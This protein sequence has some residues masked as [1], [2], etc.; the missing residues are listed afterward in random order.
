[1]VGITPTPDCHY[2]FLP[3][4]L[5]KYRHIQYDGHHAGG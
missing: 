3:H 2:L 1:M 5:A 4:K